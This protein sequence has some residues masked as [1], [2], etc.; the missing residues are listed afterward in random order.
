MC[1]PHQVLFIQSPWLGGYCTSTN[2]FENHGLLNS[3]A[4]R[5]KT[6]KSVHNSMVENAIA[7][8]RV[9]LAELGPS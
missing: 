5:D 9:N 3:L 4:K 2:D 7:Y 8:S 6:R 1:D